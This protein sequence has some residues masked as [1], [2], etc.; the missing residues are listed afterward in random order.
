MSSERKL[1]RREF[2]RTSAVAG[3]GLFSEACV[4]SSIKSQ[5]KPEVKTV[6]PTRSLGLPTPTPKATETLLPTVTPKLSEAVQPTETALIDTT[7]P[8][9]AL[10]SRE[11]QSPAPK[12]AT[13]QPTSIPVPTQ[14][15]TPAKEEPKEYVTWST[16]EGYSS[17]NGEK[18]GTV[19]P[20]KHFTVLKEEGDWLYIHLEAGGEGWIRKSE[21]A[22]GLVGT[23]PPEGA[24]PEPSKRF[25]KEIVLADGQLVIENLGTRYGV[26]V[27]QYAKRPDGTIAEGNEAIKMNSDY[28]NAMFAKYGKGKTLKIFFYDDIN[29]FP[30]RDQGKVFNNFYRYGR[31]VGGN[32]IELHVGIYGESYNPSSSYDTENILHAI[33]S[34]VMYFLMGR[35]DC[36]INYTLNQERPPDDLFDLEYPSKLT[37]TG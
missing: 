22:Y 9:V 2:L 17:P 20:G 31:D 1:S 7:T 33:N 29:K 19:I 32:V 27:T 12:K 3:V 6:E 34:N 25:P 36:V 16:I 37:V 8:A 4:P 35:Y 23:Q 26:V 18:V 11:V 14:E 10:T 21:T 13:S 15:A 30:F 28:I 5:G 24:T